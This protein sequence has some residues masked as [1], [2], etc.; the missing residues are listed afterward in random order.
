MAL[1]AAIRFAR[2]QR[3]DRF[4]ER[5]ECLPF[6]KIRSLLCEAM[7]ADNANRYAE[8]GECARDKTFHSWKLGS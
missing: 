8:E 2:E 1:K 3:E 5:L 6:R 4:S 7:T